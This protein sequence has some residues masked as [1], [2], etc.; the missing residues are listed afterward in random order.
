M[1]KSMN[2]K[3]KPEFNAYTNPSH[4]DDDYL[5]T[6]DLGIKFVHFDADNNPESEQTI[7]L[8]KFM[9][10]TSLSS[11]EYFMTRSLVAAQASK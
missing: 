10:D 3:T 9:S 4:G 8:G 1:E 2:N 5:S 11:E 6:A 7:P